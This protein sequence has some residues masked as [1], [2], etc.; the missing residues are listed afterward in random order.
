MGVSIA[1][2]KG[3]AQMVNMTPQKLNEFQPKTFK[4]FYDG[5]NDNDDDFWNSSDDEK[6]KK[7]TEV[8]DNGDDWNTSATTG[9]RKKNAQPV[10][11][12]DDFQE[13]TTKNS[14]RQMKNRDLQKYNDKIAQA[15]DLL[16]D[17]EGDKK[18]SA[19]PVVPLIEEEQ[20]KKEEEILSDTDELDNEEDGGEWVTSDNL[21]SHIGNNES[22]NLIEN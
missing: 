14:R 5:T 17:D 9:S 1:K 2:I 6:D 10:D 22:Q 11:D 7:K 13:N 20:P 3:E 19:A 18:P 21:Y 15:K 12:F 4:K 8:A 16:S